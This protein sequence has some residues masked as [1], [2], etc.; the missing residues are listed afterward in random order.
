MHQAV[1]APVNYLVRSAEKPV[2]YLSSPGEEIPQRVGQ[3]QEVQ[4]TIEDGRKDA[5]QFSLEREGFALERQKSAVRDFYDDDEVKRVYY[6]ELEEIVKAHTGASEVLVFDHT[7]RANADE[8]R[9][10]R[11]VREPVHI[12]H[13]DYTNRSAP[14]RVRDLLPDRADELLK[15]RYAVVQVWRPIVGPVRDMPLAICDAQTIGE[16]DLVET[17][18]VYDNR[19]GEVLQLTHSPGH[20][21]FYFPEM[22]ASEALVF[23]CYDSLLDGRARFTAHTA[24]A[25][26]NTPAD[27]PPRQSI[28]ARMLVFFAEQ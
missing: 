11:K 2:T 23:K 3:Y 7:I 26:P 13:N 15:H 1:H 18:L 17:D 19:V 24:F 12:A 10:A 21:W 6:P 14:Q 8:I 27:A 25:D 5:A 20:R 9:T 28:E 16:N 22:E 4:V